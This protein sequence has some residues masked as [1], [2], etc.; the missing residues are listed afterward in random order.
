MWQR[1]GARSV[2]NIDAF[3]IQEHNKNPLLSHNKKIVIKLMKNKSNIFYMSSISWSTFFLTS[4]SVM[5]PYFP[6]KLP[7]LRP[8]LSVSHTLY[9]SH[10]GRWSLFPFRTSFSPENTIDLSLPRLPSLWGPALSKHRNSDNESIGLMN[11]VS[12]KSSRHS[13]KVFSTKPTR[14]H[15]VSLRLSFSSDLQILP[16]YNDLN[17]IQPCVFLSVAP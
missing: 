13:S 9:L 16:I 7:A 15:L 3:I 12:P 1:N 5:L 11:E 10:F 2:M 17:Q 8:H 4:C 14:S 6:F